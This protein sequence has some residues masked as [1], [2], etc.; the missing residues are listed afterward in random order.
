MEKIFK[1]NELISL[2]REVRKDILSMAY[3]AKASHVGSAFSMVD[4][5]VVLYKLLLKNNP[6][7]PDDPL[8]D[9]FILSKGHACTA[10]YALLAELRYFPKEQLR[11]YAKNGSIFM[12]HINSQVP[13]V[14]F[15]TGSLGH[16]LPVGLGMALAAQ[17]RKEKWRTFVLL[18]DGELNEG[19]NWEAFGL[20]PHLKLDNLIALIDCNK[21]QSLGFTK[22]IIDLEP[23]GKKLQAFGWEVKRV[24]GHDRRKIYLALKKLLSSTSKKPKVLIADTV[25]GQGV[26]FMENTLLWHYR[27]PSEEDYEQGLKELEKSL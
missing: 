5:I 17:S 21:I 20:A 25:K 14:E 16:G 9:R 22:D 15:S 1:K 24:P 2:A 3:H 12:S 7:K 10:L 26:S 27:S 18:S 4:I 8:R 19:S 6:K 23:L 13:G 11:D